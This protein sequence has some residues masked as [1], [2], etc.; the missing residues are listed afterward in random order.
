MDAL[1]KIEMMKKGKEMSPMEKK[2]KMGIMKDIQE[3]ASKSMGGKL[4]G[5]KKVVVSGDSPESIKEGLHKAQD[6]VEKMPEEGSPEEESLESK[7]EEA[8]ESA[9]PEMEADEEDH[10]DPF[11][12]K[13]SAGHHMPGMPQDKF[14]DMSHEEINAKIK[15]LL[16][17]KARMEQKK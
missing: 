9:N 14:Q 4:D 11:A 5:L 17:Q 12:P 1:K 16:T 7:E 8:M 2:A 15:E 6:I 10:F 13:K 3:I